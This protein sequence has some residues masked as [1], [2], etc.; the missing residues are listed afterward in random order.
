MQHLPTRDCARAAQLGRALLPQA[1]SLERARSWWPF[2]RV[3]TTGALHEGTAR[4][5]SLSALRTADRRTQ[6]RIPS[7]PGRL[8]RSPGGRGELEGVLLPLVRIL[9][10]ALQDGRV[11][12]G[13]RYAAF[14][15]PQPVWRAPNPRRA[16]SSPWLGRREQSASPAQRVA[17]S[18]LGNSLRRV[19]PGEATTRPRCWRTKTAMC[20]TGLQLPHRRHL[21]ARHKTAVASDSDELVFEGVGI[22]GALSV[23]HATLPDV[24]AQR[25][26]SETS[27]VGGSRSRRRRVDSPARIFGGIRLA[28]HELDDV[29]SSG[30]ER[31]MHL[32]IGKQRRHQRDAFAVGF[33]ATD[34]AFPRVHGHEESAAR[35]QHAMDLGNGATELAARAV[36]EA[37][38]RRYSRELAV[39][40]RQVKEIAL[41]ER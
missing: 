34:L 4:L 24:V 5:L 11:L 19:S 9:P 27:R 32:V 17:S 10:Y 30:G 18:A 1:D 3:R 41:M 39:G 22:H 8:R 35:H 14:P 6:R 31:G 12:Q 21:V 37:V 25:A 26:C 36:D 29:K 7:W 2:C 40:E 33:V 20:S 23:P 28:R 38:E 15:S 16:G 13:N